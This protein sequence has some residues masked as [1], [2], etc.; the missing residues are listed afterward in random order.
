MFCLNLFNSELRDVTRVSESELLFHLK[1]AGQFSEKPTSK[2][3]WNAEYLVALS[4]NPFAYITMP[5]LFFNSTVKLN[6]LS[7]F[8]ADREGIEI[9]VSF[10][11]RVNTK[12]IYKPGQNTCISMSRDHN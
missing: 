10:C 3:N 5:P 11:S 9:Y 7:S 6:P 4:T 1:F 12:N 2:D 8:F